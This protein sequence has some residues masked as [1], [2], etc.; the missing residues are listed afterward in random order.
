MIYPCSE[1]RHGEPIPYTS[2]LY[3]RLVKRG[4]IL[5]EVGEEYPMLK[6]YAT[7]KKR[8]VLADANNFISLLFH[9]ADY[10]YRKNMHKLPVQKPALPL[11][12]DPEDGLLYISKGDKEKGTGPFV[13][14][15]IL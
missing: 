1:C 5:E 15:Q 4:A 7:S 10:K 9:I 2:K 14:S 8:K 3:Q 11:Q 13:L 12:P 6:L